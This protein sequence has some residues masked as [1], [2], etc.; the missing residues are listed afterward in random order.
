MKRVALPGLIFCLVI[1]SQ[2]ASAEGKPPHVADTFMDGW[3]V[4][5]N[6]NVLQCGRPQGSEN[7]LYSGRL[8]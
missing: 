3:T 8:D 4:S 5:G 1:L 2:K 7:H 6:T